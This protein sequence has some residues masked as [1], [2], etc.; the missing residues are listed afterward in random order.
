M[1]NRQ[2]GP[3]TETHEQ[4]SRPCL[5]H[6]NAD[7]SWLLQFPFSK[8]SDVGRKK[9]NVLVDPWFVGSQVDFAPWI[10]EQYHLIPSTVRSIDE[11]EQRLK[12]EE[13]DSS[14]PTGE[15]PAARAV[16]EEHKSFIDAVVIS[17]EF[18]DHCN[19][20]T[21]LEVNPLVPIYATS[22]AAGLIR[23]WKHFARVHDI[24][25]L[26]RE[27]RHRWTGC[28]VQIA[29]WLSASRLTSSRDVGYLHSGVLITYPI[30]NPQEHGHQE[31]ILYTP[32]GIVAGDVR[33]LSDLK[34]P[35]NLLALIHGLHEVSATFLLKINLG[36]ANGAQLG[37]FLR[38][39]YWIVTH[40][41]VKDG[42]GLIG[43]VLRRKEW[44]AE[45]AQQMQAHHGSPEDSREIGVWPGPSQDPSPML[46]SLGSGE[47][48][49]LR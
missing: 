22:A 21:L 48:L 46:L 15:H 45:E 1:D 37:N 29:P 36:A 10:S 44:R 14:V 24:P 41:E 39:R 5:T 38:A 18:T 49:F 23:S 27:N 6:L 25:V 47:S 30:S 34:P 28:A 12:A 20:H 40:D 16:T 4:F 8:P 32:H 17:H 31:G 35:V 43:K 33:W 2:H 9:F 13:S 42:R 7:T 26:T 19:K 11:L 3:A